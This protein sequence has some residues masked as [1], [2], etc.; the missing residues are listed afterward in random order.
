MEFTAGQHRSL[1]QIKTIIFDVDHVINHYGSEYAR[2][3]SA[4]TAVSFTE[5]YHQKAERFDIDE[6]T[7]LAIGSYRK[8][9]RTTAEFA[10]RFNIN[11]MKLYVHHHDALCEQ[12]GYI[13]RQFE[14]GEIRHDPQLAMCLSILKGMGYRLLAVSNGTK[15]YVEKTLSAGCHDV[16]H[17]FDGLYGMDSFDNPFMLD[18]RHGAFWA[19]ILDQCGLLPRFA[20]AK[21]EGI[22][23]DFWDNSILFID[24]S[25][26]NHRAPRLIFNMQTVLKTDSARRQMPSWAHM[27]THDL[28]DFLTSLINLKNSIPSA[29]N[30]RLVG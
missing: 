13:D 14:Y 6:L 19:E 25:H 20:D 26:A 29:P 30:L 23:H 1:S 9:G 17:L 12:G 22:P 21:G 28:C 18:K 8:T 3:F 10:K 24:D 11:E 15:G 7:D 4:A 16:G 2:E 27:Q 5:L